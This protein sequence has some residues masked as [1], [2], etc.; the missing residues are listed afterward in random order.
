MNAKN[1]TGIWKTDGLTIHAIGTWDI[2]IATLSHNVPAPERKANAQ[3]IA[4]S[5]EMLSVLAAVKDILTQAN[6]GSNMTPEKVSSLIGVS[7]DCI[8]AVIAKATGEQA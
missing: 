5:P 2:N 1:T 7:L 8:D 6:T 3:L 4:T